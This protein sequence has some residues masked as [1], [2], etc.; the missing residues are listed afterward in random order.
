MQ[1]NELHSWDIPTKEAIKWQEMLSH[2]ISF[3]PNANRLRLIAGVD[4]SYQKE[5]IIGGI[6]ILKYP[7]LI[8]LDRQY[9][10]KKVNFPYISGLLTFREGPVLV[11][12]FKIVKWNPDI[13]FFDGQ[14]IA[15]PRRMG[16]ATHMGLFLDRPT[17]GCAKS[18]LI[19]EYTN[20]AIRK[21]SY[22]L[23]FH[24]GMVIGAVLRTRYKV[25]PL[26]ISPGN[27]MNLQKAVKITLLCTPKF[28]IPEPVRQAHLFVNQI[29]KESLG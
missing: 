11:D 17:I 28:R 22:S 23:L 16:I 21:G 18:R 25:K 3:S 6:V 19:G 2:K 26:F 29:R 7:E 20:P 12:L 24:Q 5:Y 4:A 15:H 27:H 14:G 13:I 9:M 10:V 1:L 8:L